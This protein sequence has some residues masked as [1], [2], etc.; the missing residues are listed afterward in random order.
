MTS[1]DIN[2]I[3]YS[4]RHAV[5]PEKMVKILADLYQCRNADI[6][7]LLEIKG[8]E[9]IKG[10]SDK[11]KAKKWTAAE[12]EIVAEESN[13]GTPL[14]GIK[15]VLSKHGYTRSVDGIAHKQ[16]DLRSANIITKPKRWSEDMDAYLLRTPLKD[17][18]LQAE[19]NR[20]FNTRYYVCLLN[21][22]KTYLHWRETH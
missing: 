13:K 6:E 21:N 17:G 20:K 19:F 7:E 16:Q 10:K 12:E 3:C 1:I 9:V 11:R 14:R 22:R 4:Y 5:E 15:E 2:Y 8:I 18:E